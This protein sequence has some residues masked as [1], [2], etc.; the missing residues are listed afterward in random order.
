MGTIA[1]IA[2]CD[3]KAA[4]IAFV[5]ERIA[6]NGH[7]AF[8]IDVS[9]SADHISTA[10][11]TREEVIASTGRLWGEFAGQS[12]DVL[13]AAIAEGAAVTTRRLQAE[14]AID[15]IL[16]LGGLQNT[17][18]AA[19]A[20]Q[21]LPIGFP[22][23][24]VSTVA[25]G[26][27]T[28]GPI[29]GTSDI[30]VMPSITD[31][32]GLNVISETVLINAAAAVSGMVRDGRRGVPRSDRP[33]VGTTLMGA[34]NDGVV[35][36]AELLEAAGQPVMCFHSTGVGGQVLEELIS[37]GTI[38]GAMDLTLHE[39]VY[40][41]FGGGFGAGTKDR[42]CAGVRAGI[43]MVVVP[44]GVDFI[45]Q[46]R[47]SLFDDISERK[48]IWHN[49]QLAHVKLRVEEVTA[50]AKIIVE[51]LNAATGPVKVLFPARGLRT[52]AQPGEPLHDPEVDNTILAVL[53]SG[54]RADIPLE[55]VDASIMDPEFSRIAADSMREL[56]AHGLVDVS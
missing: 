41:Y 36:A 5:S 21:S 30:T 52:F 39:L 13:L 27:R 48:M 4:E 40:E 14:G 10:Q 26:S 34:T 9:T 55:V 37:D 35:A 53:Q 42:L 54:L 17:T 28:F 15:G 50:I 46:W 3:T 47:E 7:R 22:K 24:I 2:C 25:S 43:P 11:V 31:L 29:V 38:S 12:K 23:V 16:G 19:Q 32:A 51:R 45:C 20:M 6:K 18:I 44:G 33:I 1:V 49:A 56:M 8:V